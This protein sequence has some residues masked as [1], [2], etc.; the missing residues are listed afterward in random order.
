MTN[1]RWPQPFTC[2][3]AAAPQNTSEDE[4]GLVYYMELLNANSRLFD[5]YKSVLQE[6]IMLRKQS[7]QCRSTP[8][9]D[10]DSKQDST[11]QLRE[12]TSRHQPSEE[13]VEQLRKKDVETALRP[14]LEICCPHYSLS[15][16]GLEYPIL[17]ICHSQ[18]W[19]RVQHQRIKYLVIVVHYTISP[20]LWM[21]LQVQAAALVHTR[22]MLLVMHAAFTLDIQPQVVALTTQTINQEGLLISQFLLALLQIRDALKPGFVSTFP[23][24]D[25]AKRSPRG[26]LTYRVTSPNRDSRLSSIQISQDHTPNVALQRQPGL[27]WCAK[28]EVK[29]GVPPSRLA[30]LHPWGD[31]CQMDPPSLLLNLG[32][33]MHMQAPDC[34][35]RVPWPSVDGQAGS[36]NAGYGCRNPLASSPQHLLH[37]CVEM[38][39]PTDPEKRDRQQKELVRK[40]GGSLIR[41]AEQLGRLG[42]IFVYIVFHDPQYGYD[43]IVNIPEGF[44]EPNIKKMENGR[45]QNNELQASSNGIA[46]IDAPHEVD[47]DFKTLFGQIEVCN[48]SKVADLQLV[49]T[50][51]STVLKETTDRLTLANENV[52]KLRTT[53]RTEARSKHQLIVNLWNRLNETQQADNKRVSRKRKYDDFLR[54]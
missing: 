53:A 22:K 40:R 45:Q 35:A 38:A 41:K 19:L 32:V 4:S 42:N 36:G 24:I 20:T 29:R 51:A 54:G 47:A 15:N 14:R 9:S 49:K 18:F 34:S 12:S 33:C 1:P 21:K 23:K 2:D 5:S 39:R 43:G 26:G 52:Q 8:E 27:G 28:T 6:N 30:P 37:N 25:A 7:A 10:A 50:Q 17:A 31:Y 11:P 16:S 13:R 46:E 44:E 3:M 48:D